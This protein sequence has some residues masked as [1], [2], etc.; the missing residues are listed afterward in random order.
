MT[1]QE[2]FCTREDFHQSVGYAKVMEAIGWC[3]IPVNGSRLSHRPLGPVSLAKMQR[4]KTID[5]GKINALR[6]RLHMLHVIIE[7]TLTGTIVDGHGI[8]HEYSFLTDQETQ[9]SKHLFAQEH[10]TTSSERYAHSKTAIIDLSENLQDVVA[11]FPSK[12]RYNIRLSAKKDIHYQSVPFHTLDDSTIDEFFTMHALWSKEKH[13]TGYSDHFLRVVFASFASAG[14]MIEARDNGKLVG[15]MLILSHDRI[16][17]YF[18]TC[19]SPIGRAKHVPTGMLF[20]ALTLS[21]EQGADIFDFCS[22]YDERYP[23][24]HPRWIGFSTFKDRFRPTP[25]YYPPSFHRWV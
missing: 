13:V 17:Y 5:L 14:W 1:L 16:G 4:P 2:R 22:V 12:T 19:S 10:F 24:D 23:Q 8:R 7:P 20:E 15:A 11:N 21:K 6:T 25:I 3:S 9:K 18:Y